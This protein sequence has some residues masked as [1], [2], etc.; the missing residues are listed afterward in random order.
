MWA[1]VPT[2]PRL[3]SCRAGDV[4][5]AIAPHPEDHLGRRFRLRPHSLYPEIHHPRTHLGLPKKI[6]NRPTADNR[7]WENR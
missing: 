7:F 3:V 1:Q 6:E 5:A 4:D 2:L